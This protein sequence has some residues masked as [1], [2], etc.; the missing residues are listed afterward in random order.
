MKPLNII[1]ILTACLALQ[2]CIVA[3]AAV[4]ATGAVVGTGVKVVGAVGRAVIPGESKKD[5]EAREF[6]AWQ[7]AHK[8]EKP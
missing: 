1:V 7:K 8:A 2:G 4:G 3:G 5:R 6:K